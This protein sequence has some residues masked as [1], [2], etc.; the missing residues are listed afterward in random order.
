MRQD[1]RRD[2]CNLGSGVFEGFEGGFMIW[3]DL[4]MGN[5]HC[6]LISTV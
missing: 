3:L 1:S 6:I 2:L 5:K 4:A